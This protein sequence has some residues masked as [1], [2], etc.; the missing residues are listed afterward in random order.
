MKRRGPVFYGILTFFYPL[1]LNTEC[2]NQQSESNLAEAGRLLTVQAVDSPR[3]AS[4][5]PAAEDN[6]RWMRPQD[7]YRIGSP[8][9]SKTTSA[10]S[11]LA[12]C[13]VRKRR[14]QHAETYFAQSRN[15]LRGC[16]D[17]LRELALTNV[18]NSRTSFSRLK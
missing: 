6:K 14:M 10:L 17:G 9:L 5:R 18:P 4:K 7:L 12:G 8:V 15:Q 16:W 11:K 3:A 2:A 13:R 1:P